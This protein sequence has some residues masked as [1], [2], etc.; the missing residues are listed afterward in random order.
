M[1]VD[2]RKQLSKHLGETKLYGN[3][4]VFISTLPDTFREG[5]TKHNI[6]IYP[7]SFIFYTALRKVFTTYR[8]Y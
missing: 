1:E 6:V 8:T 2:F 3:L 4:T 7:L 5:Y